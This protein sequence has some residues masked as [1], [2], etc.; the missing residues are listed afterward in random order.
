MLD[1]YIGEFGE[2]MLNELTH[3][4]LQDTLISGGVQEHALRHCI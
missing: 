4:G 2:F 3:E 1:T